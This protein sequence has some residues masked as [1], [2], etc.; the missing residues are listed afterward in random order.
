MKAVRILL[1]GSTLAL[2]LMTPMAAP[3]VAGARTTAMTPARMTLLK[4]RGHLAIQRRLIELDRLT[5]L[6]NGA[7]HLSSANRTALVSKLSA[8]RGGLESLD[9]KIQG[10]TDASTLRTDLESIVTAYRIYVL[11][12]PQAH[13]AVASDRVA[14]FVSLGNTIAGQIQA[15]IDTAKGNGKDVKVAQAALNE[16]RKQLQAATAAIAGIASNVIALTPSGYPANRSMLISARISILAA[17]AHL[18]KA[19]VDAHAAVS[20]LA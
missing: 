17:R 13:L 11:V 20:A 6:V 18:A 12:A 1:I 15:A 8:D 3:A 2:A 10:D 5:A 14:A 16:M 9:T 4:A 7:T 19:R